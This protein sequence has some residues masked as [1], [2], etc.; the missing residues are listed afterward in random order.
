MSYPLVSILC[1]VYNH[2][3]YLRQ[4][5][6]GFVMQRAFYPI[7]VLIHDDA[8]TDNSANIIREYEAKYPGLFKALYQTENKYSK[9]IDIDTGIQFVRAKGKY[10]ALCEGDDYWTD[11]LKI[12]K[13]VDFLESHEDYVMCC[14]AFTQSFEDDSQAKITVSF[15]LDEI[16]IDDFLKGQWIGTLT[17]VFRK[18]AI[19]DYVVPFKGLPMGDLPLWGHLL[20]K[21]RIKYLNDI[22]ANYRRH[23][24]SA[25]NPKDE[26]KGAAFDLAA[27]RVREYYALSSNRIA[28]AAPSLKKNAQFIIDQAYANKRIGFPL[29]GF[30]HFLEE[31]GHPSGYDKLKRWGLKSNLNYFVSRIILR[32]KHKI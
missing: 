23:E 26:K 28:V 5:L 17:A 1:A 15:D 22:T 24:C 14:T 16:T 32:L 4:C 18:N 6:D 7:E 8:S 21:G 20:L 19:D 13:Q 3:P 9:G 29:E 12:Q 10:I 2:E 25:S 27:M 11:P 31:Y 30:W